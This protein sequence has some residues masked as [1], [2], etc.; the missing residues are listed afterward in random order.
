M[1]ETEVLE[2][3]AMV[4][5]R[6]QEDMRETLQRLQKK[7]SKEVSTLSG[8]DLARLRRALRHSTTL[9]GALRAVRS[10]AS[11]SSSASRAQGSSGFVELAILW[12]RCRVHGIL[13]AAAAARDAPELRRALA[14]AEA[15]GLAVEM[16]KDLCAE[17]EEREAAPEEAAQEPS[18]APSSAPG[19]ASP[20][21]AGEGSPQEAEVDAM[22]APPEHGRRW[23][24]WLWWRRQPDDARSKWR[25]DTQLMHA[26]HDHI[27]RGNEPLPVELA[28]DLGLQPASPSL[29]QGRGVGTT[30]KAPRPR[31]PPR[32]R[33]GNVV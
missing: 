3:Q 31:E 5:S 16:E 23:E 27:R 25:R 8:S 13:A 15:V 20:S 28:I 4:I 21:E 6:N 9:N 18:E 33:A 11:F 2:M 17:L 10:A 32:S 26:V 1:T 30:S 14:R 22:A 29:V 7:W 19:S 24:R 12:E